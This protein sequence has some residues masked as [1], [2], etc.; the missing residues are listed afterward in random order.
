MTAADSLRSQ[1]ISA[2]RRNGLSQVQVGRALGISTKH[3]SQMITGKVSLSLDRAEQILGLC[4]MQLTISLTYPRL[5]SCGLCFEE[6]GEEC[7]PHPECTR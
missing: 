3:M 4:G 2:L 1:V 7:H 6:N 5:L